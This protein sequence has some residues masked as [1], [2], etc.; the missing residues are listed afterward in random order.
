VLDFCVLCQSPAL[1]KTNDSPGYWHCPHSMRSRVYATVG[2]R[3]AG[4]LLWARQ[5]GDNYIDRLQPRCSTAASGTS[6]DVGSWPQTWIENNCLLFTLLAKISNTTLHFCTKQW[7]APLKHRPNGFSNTIHKLTDGGGYKY[8][9]SQPRRWTFATHRDVG[10]TAVD[11]QCDKLAN[12]VGRN[13]EYCHQFI[14]PSVHLYR[15]STTRCDRRRRR[16]VVKFCKCRVDGDNVS[17]GSTLIFEDI[18]IC[19]RNSVGWVE[20]SLHVK[21]EVDPSSR[22][23]RTSACVRHRQAPGDS[24]LAGIHAGSRG[25]KTCRSS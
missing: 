13:R 2:R 15:T 19:P 10:D 23:D 24:Y 3:F 4:L 11:A 5:P 9:L 25:I 1:Y 21:Y 6:A 18:R 14:T 7:N 20:G 12:V 17:E 16:A 8:Q 22:L